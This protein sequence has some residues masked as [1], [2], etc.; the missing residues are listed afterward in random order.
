[1]N[2]IQKWDYLWYALYSFAGLGI[3]VLL[4]AFVEPILFARVGI[5]NYTAVQMII[6][7]LM[8]IFCWAAVSFFLIRSAKK[9]LKFDV[10]SHS[11][12]TTRNIALA[13]FLVVVCVAFHA[14]DWAGLKIIEEFQKKGLLLF[15]FQYLY[16]FVEV[17]LVFLIVA[18]GQQF[19][20]SLLHKKSRIPWGGIVLCC[21]WGAV[22]I[23]SKG[24]IYTGLVMMA[25]SLAYGLMYLLLER[26]TR[27]SYFAIALAFMV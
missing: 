13:M 22:H 23:L 25:F 5:T 11:K 9:K 7:W 19:F 2:K 8:T 24:S 20:E 18:F 27:W 14:F 4:I 21:T 12:P 1:M 15:M 17:L 6:H 16:Y 10:I 26:N 3:E